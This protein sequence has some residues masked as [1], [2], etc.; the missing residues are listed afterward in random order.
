M[1]D[2]GT[3]DFESRNPELLY[4]LIS[5]AITLGVLGDQELHSALYFVGSN[6]SETK[7][8]QMTTNNGGKKAKQY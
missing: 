8:S 7:M 2:A 1:G 6:M 4:T 3:I 5:R